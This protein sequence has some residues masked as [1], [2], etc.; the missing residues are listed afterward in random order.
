MVVEAHCFDIFR[1]ADLSLSLSLA[2]SVY[3]KVS[4]DGSEKERKTAQKSA[5]SIV[6]AVRAQCQSVARFRAEAAEAE[7]NQNERE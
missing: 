2:H 1:Y 6:V 3:T 5:G 7:L 4:D